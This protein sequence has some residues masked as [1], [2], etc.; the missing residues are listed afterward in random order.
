VGEK[1]IG[2]RPR[3]VFDTNVLVGAAYAPESASRR[4]VE[5]CLR[6]RLVAVLS[7][8]VAEEYEHIL[9]R[10]VR[11]PD[12]QDA[13]RQFLGRAVVVEPAET[14]RAVPDDPA[15]DKLLAAAVA[16]AADALVT[17][18]RHLLALDPYGAL[19]IVRPAD[20]LRMWPAPAER[21]EER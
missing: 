16:A 10:A 2:S 21:G 19:R 4:L 17:N 7:P 3:V 6:G 20:F 14:P 5:A 8:A 11:T 9:P 13:L 15:D 18:D 1:S 12:Y